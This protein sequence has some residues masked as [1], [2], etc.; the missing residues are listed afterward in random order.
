[1]V[2]GGGLRL[3]SGANA[4]CHIFDSKVQ[5]DGRTWIGTASCDA[6]TGNFIPWVRCL[7]IT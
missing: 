2:T 7:S 4:A 6:A 5:P 3:G 1:M